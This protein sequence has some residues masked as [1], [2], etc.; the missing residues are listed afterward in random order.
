MEK[1]KATSIDKTIGN[2]IKLRKEKGLS[3][4]NMANELAISVAAYHKIEKLE[5]KLTVE[6]LLQIIEILNSSVAEI[7][8]V[9][10]ENIYHQQ[11]KDQGIGHQQIENLYQDN[12]VITQKLIET[13]RNEIDFLKTLI[14]K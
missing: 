14:K 6:R 7:F 8:N 11:I 2:I 3:L 12:Q 5:S 1:D 13:M 10:T 9:Q 4:E